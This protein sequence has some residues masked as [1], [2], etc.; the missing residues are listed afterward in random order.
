MTFSAGLTIRRATGL[1]MGM[2][3]RQPPIDPLFS[4]RR[5]ADACTLQNE[6]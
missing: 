1:R 2:A 3:L 4:V 6:G 5:G